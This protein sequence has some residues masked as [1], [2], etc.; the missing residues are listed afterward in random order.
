MFKMIGYPQLDS[1]VVQ[2]GLTI[3]YMVILVLFSWVPHC[4][5]DSFLELSNI[6]SRSMKDNRRQWK[7]ILTIFHEH[8]TSLNHLLILF[9]FSALDLA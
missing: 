1:T 6:P 9:F 3:R 2:T 5:L 8:A 4:L 7:D